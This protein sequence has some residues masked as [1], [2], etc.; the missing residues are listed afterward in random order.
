MDNEGRVSSTT[1]P[2]KAGSEDFGER[3][4]LFH[5]GVESL[6]RLAKAQMGKERVGK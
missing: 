2:I 4:F 5:V 3:L 1:D 6:Q